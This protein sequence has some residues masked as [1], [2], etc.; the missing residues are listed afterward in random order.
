MEKTENSIQI[1][2]FDQLSKIIPSSI[3]LVDVL[4]DVLNISIDSA[5]RRL[6]CET[7]L[8]INEIVLLCSTYNISFDSLYESAGNT[9]TFDFST[10][11]DELNYGFCPIA[12]WPLKLMENGILLK[13]NTGHSDE[14]RI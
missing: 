4:A 14:F 3:S 8:N 12:N 9:V 2:L 6:R 5:Y 13:Y 11:N 10:M 1:K 7:F